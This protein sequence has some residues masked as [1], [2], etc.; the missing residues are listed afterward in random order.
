[1]DKFEVIE[2]EVNFYKDTPLEQ[3]PTFAPKMGDVYN[4]ID[5]FSVS[6]FRDGDKDSL[7]Y[8]K[9]FYNIVN[10]IVDVCA[11]MLDIDTKHIYLKA[12]EGQSYWAPWIMSKELKFWMKDKYFARQLNKYCKEYPK[13]GDLWTKKVKD[14]VKWIPPQNMIYRVNA[15]DYKTIPLI[16]RHEYGA[17][18]LKIVGKQNK[19]KNIDE[20][21][22]GSGVTS[23][24]P[25]TYNS[26]IGVKEDNIN[27]GIVIYEA[28]FPVGYLEEKNNW[29]IISKDSNKVLA[30]AFKKN[31]P[32]KKLAWE[33]LPGRL[34]GRG[35]VEQCFEE[36]IYLNRIANYKSSGFHWTSKHWYQTKYTGIGKDNISSYDD[37]HLII[38]PSEITPV[39]NEE[40][41]LQAYG[42]EE[43]RYGENAL[44][45]TFSTEPL[46]GGKSPSGTTLGATILQTQQA[47]AFYKQ[48]RE[49]LA[50]F[51]KEILWDWVLPEF[52][53]QKRK[54]HKILIQTLIED[55]DG[56]S[57]KF[58]NLML[59]ERMNKLRSTSK[60]LSPEQWA[61]RKSIQS[62]L[63]K[64]EDMVI[65]KGFYD[66]L[67]YKID[68]IITGEQIDVQARQSVIMMLVQMLN[69]NPAIFENKKI[70][71]FL[72]YALNLIGMNPKDFFDDE[73]PTMPEL[74][75]A[76]RAQRG[77]SIAA[78]QQVSN[79]AMSQVEQQ[80]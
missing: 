52:K 34:P 46:S 1:M 76:G 48:K 63:L 41:N 80:V 5:L 17:D 9:V 61:I 57:D 79:P 69:S 50:E 28:W 59:N 4:L 22:A 47:T 45:K 54:E 72:S 66:N 51:I 77:G 65:P 33:E 38:S 19:W 12:V 27:S 21:I 14:D 35:R 53:N 49:E 42:T 11:K 78:P 30:E 68:I 18:E 64:K 71:R 3:N 43:Q 56:E 70:V 29:F 10:F 15:T 36:Q 16:E 6:R 7:G 13:Y 67:K 55:N 26:N 20:T 58:F 8:R 25:P 39:V 23:Q 31:C 2:N 60:Y 32:Y 73:N 75:G 44:K 40:R 62:E 24:T 74:A 37:G